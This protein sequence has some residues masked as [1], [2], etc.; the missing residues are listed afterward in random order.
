MKTLRNVLASCFAAMAMLGVHAAD[1]WPA[2]PISF[3]VPFAPGGITDLAARTLAKSV[4][5][6]L[7]QPVVVENRAGAS[8]SLGAE[9]VARQPADGYTILFGTSSTHASNLALYKDVRYDPVA[10]FVPVYGI[11]ATPL[12]L[13]V[14]PKL[15]LK[16]VAQLVA[17]AKANPGKLN[18]AS[19]GAG[20]APHLAAA[21]FQHTTATKMTHVPYKG[22]APALA[23]M[24]GGSVDL[25]FDY[26]PTVAPYLSR[27]QLV[28]LA[29]TGTA[30]IAGLED[31]PTMAEA[32]APG[33]EL[34]A[35][36]AV[37]A[38]A[39]TPP[40]VVNALAD[41]FAAAATQPEFA[42][43]IR[44]TGS[45]PLKDARDAALAGFV[46][47]E[48]ARWRDIVQMSGAKLD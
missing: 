25:L 26:G 22:A 2:R 12:V 13:V 9:H 15:P 27:K 41:A 32:G 16:T 17:Y 43:L 38:P 44:R 5:A 28:P 8:G 10:D 35:W 48:A 36:S 7:G 45:V 24:L 33:A 20:T 6:R 30:A 34:I 31:V 39:R 23:D 47:S 46:K 1:A 4:A 42:S 11:S 29:V 19:A 21:L 14:N 37:F 3:V 18:F 40:E